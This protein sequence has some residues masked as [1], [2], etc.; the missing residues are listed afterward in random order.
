MTGTGSGK[1]LP[2]R[3][4]SGVP[5]IMVRDTVREPEGRKKDAGPGAGFP[6]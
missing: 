3:H 2:N 6:R 5:G 1:V 4:L